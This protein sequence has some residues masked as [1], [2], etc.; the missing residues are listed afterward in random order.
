LSS[1]RYARL[2]I[3]AATSS[4][5][6]SDGLGWRWMHRRS[7]SLLRVSLLPEVEVTATSLPT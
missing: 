4:L 6:E 7:V 1:D 5:A 3:L 2:G